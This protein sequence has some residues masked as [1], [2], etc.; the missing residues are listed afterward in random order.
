MQVKIGTKIAN[1]SFGNMPRVQIF[2]NDS[3]K[4]KFD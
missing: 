3:N 1:R 4:S 2:G